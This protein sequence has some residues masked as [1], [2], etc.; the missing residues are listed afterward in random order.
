LKDLN[1]FKLV[2]KVENVHKTKIALIYS[3]DI[4]KRNIAASNGLGINFDMLAEDLKFFSYTL[5]CYV[6]CTLSI[7]SLN[8]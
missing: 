1:L 3:D 7:L 5:E 8:G 6:I 4:N 2:E